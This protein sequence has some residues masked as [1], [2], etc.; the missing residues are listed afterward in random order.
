MAG[1]AASIPLGEEIVGVSIDLT[2]IDGGT[3]ALANFSGGFEKV[4]FTATPVPASIILSPGAIPPPAFG[5]HLEQAR[6]SATS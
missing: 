4:D 2:L 3:S 5:R 6:H 1:V